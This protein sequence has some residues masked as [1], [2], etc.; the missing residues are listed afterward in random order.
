MNKPIIKN[1]PLQELS[2]REKAVVI[3]NIMGEM[4]CYRIA[5]VFG[6]SHHT[7]TSIVKRGLAKLRRRKD[8]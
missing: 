2:D 6:V 5:I 8:G 3:L 1:V 7:I 4:T